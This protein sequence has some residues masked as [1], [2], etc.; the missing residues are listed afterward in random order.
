M[1]ILLN[2]IILKF[3]AIALEDILFY[4]YPL[5]VFFPFSAG[6][7]VWSQ[8]VTIAMFLSKITI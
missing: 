8:V 2:L 4:N 1:I 6:G 7:A 3:V 5:F